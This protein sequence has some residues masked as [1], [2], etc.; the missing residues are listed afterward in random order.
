MQFIEAEIV[1]ILHNLPQPAL[2]E[3][4]VFMDFLA[5]RY[6]TSQPTEQ[7]K[8]L[9]GAMRGKANTGLTTDEIMNMS[10]SEQ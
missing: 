4:K 9:I 2:E 7:G 6:R 5:W 3:A 8:S 10:R 1:A